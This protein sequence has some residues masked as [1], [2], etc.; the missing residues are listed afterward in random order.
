MSQ[1]TISI[2]G[3]GWLGLPLAEKLIG[4]GCAVRGSTTTPD[5]LSLL[6][7]KGIEPFLIRFRPWPD[8]DDVTRFLQTDVLIVNIPPKA[9]AM[10]DSFH[11]Q[12]I[13]TLLEHLPAGTPP[14]IIYISSTSVYPEL[15]REVVETDVVLPEESAAPALVEAEQL[16]LQTGNSTVLRCAGL[17]GYD[18]IP[19]KYV[20][21]KKGLTTGGIPVNYVHRDDTV[22]IIQHLIETP[23]PG[24]TFNVVAPEHPTREAVYRKSCADFGYELPTFAEPSEPVPYKVISGGKLNEELQYRFLFPDPLAFFYSPR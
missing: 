11:P 12:S 24:Q 19:G 4:S 20:A 16:M 14:C 17:M 22:R 13:R 15:N 9:G 8:G 1:K 18:R 6:T 2:L 7:E 10:G 21:G 5:K 3:C 23:R